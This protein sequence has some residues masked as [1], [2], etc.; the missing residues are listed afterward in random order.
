MT[1]DTREREARRDEGDS[2]ANDGVRS[3]LAGSGAGIAGPAP[4]GGDPE[5]L[6]EGPAG[7]E[8]TPTGA[9]KTAGGGYGS[10][11][12]VQSSGGTGEGDAPAGDDAQTDWLRA[13]EGR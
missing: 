11:S 8:E 4:A 6:A 13:S 7:N 5:R 12:E 1:D 2:A 9:G 10:G 3:D